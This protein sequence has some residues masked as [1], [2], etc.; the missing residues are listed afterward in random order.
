MNFHRRDSN[1]HVLIQNTRMTAWRVYQFHHFGMLI[2]I[3]IFYF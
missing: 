2:Q 1:P 3:Y